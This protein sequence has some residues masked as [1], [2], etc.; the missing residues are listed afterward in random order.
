MPQSNSIGAIA[1]AL[2]KAQT[3]LTNPEKSL[4]AHIPGPIGT[5]GRAQVFRYAPLS[6]GLEIVRKCL[7]KQE[8]A[9]TQTTV[10]DNE[11]G[12]VR[13]ITL[14]AHSSGEWISSDWPVCT[15]SNISS[16]QKMG[17]SLTYARRYALFSLVGIAGEDDLDAP[18]LPHE[19]ASPSNGPHQAYQSARVASNSSVR[20]K[21]T[22]PNQRLLGKAESNSLRDQLIAELAGM[23]SADE[24]LSWA[25]RVMPIK[26]TLQGDDAAA[27]DDAFREKMVYVTNNDQAVGSS[28]ATDGEDAPELTPR[29]SVRSNR[30]KARKAS[31]EPTSVGKI[32]KSALALGA[33]K[34]HRSKVH[35]RLVASHPC[36]VCGRQPCDAHHLRHAQPRGLGQKVSDEYTVPLCRIHHREVHGKSQEAAWWKTLRIDPLKIASDLWQQTISRDHASMTR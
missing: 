21:T 35:L 24:L 7:G 9:L 13:L 32:D 18:D 25:L 31:K 28:A 4:T 20:T 33:P 11:A 19:S 8:I 2:A 16:P 6:A 30:A 34:R 12:V 10:V 1:A 27:V 14:L 36:L 17:M 26:N 3:E 5:N 29:Q 15:T 22:Q 23:S